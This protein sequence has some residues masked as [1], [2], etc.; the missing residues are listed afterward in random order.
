FNFSKQKPK[1]LFKLKT[2][3]TQIRIVEISLFLSYSIPINY[4]VI[5]LQKQ[6]NHQ[7]IQQQFFQMDIEIDKLAQSL[8]LL[9]L[10]DEKPIPLKHISFE[11]N[12][13]YSQAN[14]II[15]QEYFNDS[16]EALSTIFVF[17][18]ESGNAFSKLTM[19]IDG[20][21]IETIIEERKIAEAKFVEAVKKN[22]TAVIGTYTKSG[23]SDDLFKIKLGNIPPQKKIL[24]T[25]LVHQTLTIEDMSY[26][27]RLPFKYIP[28]YSPPQQVA[29]EV[30]QAFQS[31]SF[32]QFEDNQ[33]AGKYTWDLTINLEAAG[34][35][36]R[37]Q[38]NFKIEIQQNG[39]KQAIIKS[40]EFKERPEKDFKLLFQDTSIGNPIALLGENHGDAGIIL[41]MVPD[42]RSEEL[43][44]YQESLIQKNG[45]QF[46]S[47]FVMAPD[48]T[49]M[50]RPPQN[51]NIDNCD[52]YFSNRQKWINALKLFIYSLP[53]GSRFNIYSF[54]SDYEKV[55][56]Q[57]VEYNDQTLQEAIRIVSEFDA[58]LGGTELFQP[59]DNIYRETKKSNRPQQIFLLTDGSVGNENEITKLI[60][61]NQKPNLRL[62]SFGIGSGVSTSLI[63][64]S[65][66]KGGGMFYFILSN[67]DIE[68]YVIEALQVNLLPYL[69]IEEIQL[70]D[71][72]NDGTDI[73]GQFSVSNG[74]VFQHKIFLE[75]C[76]KDFKMVYFKIYDPN[77]QQR[78]EVFI[79]ILKHPLINENIMTSTVAAELK[80][81]PNI[82]DKIVPLSI[83]HQVIS[84]F[85]SFFAARKIMNEYQK[86]DL[87]KVNGPKIDIDVKTLTGKTLQ[88]FVNRHDTVEELKFI[89]QSKE[90]IP[91][92]QQRLIYAGKQLED[93]RKLSDYNIDDGACLHLVLRLRG[94]GWS[95]KFVNLLD[96]E[97]QTFFDMNQKATEALM[98]VLKKTKFPNFI[99]FYLQN[100]QEVHVKDFNM[101][102]QEFYQQHSGAHKL[103]ICEQISVVIEEQNQQRKTKQ[104][105]HPDLEL[106]Q[107]IANIGFPPNQIEIYI[108]GKLYKGDIKDV[109]LKQ[110][111]INV[112]TSI[113]IVKIINYKSI[114]FL[115]S[116]VGFWDQRLI[117]QYLNEQNVEQW[118]LKQVLPVKDLQVLCTLLALKLLKKDYDADKHLWSMIERKANNYL[119]KF[120][121]S[122]EQIEEYIKQIII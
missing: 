12:V 76:N 30:I 59:L 8:Y 108:D 66:Q 39:N 94:G 74:A 37:C 32:E 81:L 119:V 2:E 103:I 68:K 79:E 110:A 50:I 5:E 87:S 36:K 105:F 25:I 23:R 40:N 49:Q 80:K 22:E 38:S 19:T 21:E 24:I 113:R 118:A 102:F 111:G 97:I 112:Q 52:Y 43:K 57:I 65:A 73:K 3:Q 35:L 53:M 14:L 45:Y 82:K 29:K 114:V 41:S 98:A 31:H 28:R 115:Q 10:D 1:K 78:N 106:K 72:E 11:A 104:N 6:I 15:K 86:L 93:G 90:G 20:E 89:I 71:S 101:T 75:K 26:C 9:T 91:P 120:G 54:G 58:D 48:A 109:T 96:E 100:E 67:Q 69:N 44:Q 55:F 122:K 46:P 17:P 84:S 70:I 51:F 116:A 13:F 60:Q 16:K 62:H 83:K 42:F 121:L 47:G 34:N 56:P 64:N 92:D 18:V 4:Y 117:V 61:R 95:L 88:I 27:F 33:Q 7:N 85:T 77:T 63:N 99:V 107:F